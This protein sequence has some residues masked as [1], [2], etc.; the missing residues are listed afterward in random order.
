MTTACHFNTSI[1]FDSFRALLCI[2][3]S[4][5]VNAATRTAAFLT[6]KRRACALL[7]LWWNQSGRLDLLRSTG[8]GEKAALYV[9]GTKL[10][11]FMGRLK[12]RFRNAENACSKSCSLVFF[13]DMQSAMP[14]LVYISLCPACSARAA[15]WT[16][17]CADP[18]RMQESADQASSLSNPRQERSR[19]PFLLVAIPLHRQLLVSWRHVQ[20]APSGPSSIGRNEILELSHGSAQDQVNL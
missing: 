16:N 19:F 13:S 8:L 4:S 20:R 9:S 5:M 11:P 10:I 1:R 15:T 2:A 14:K 6:S 17:A 7:P 3:D 12:A 18:P